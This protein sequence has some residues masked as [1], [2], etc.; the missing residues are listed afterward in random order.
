MRTLTKVK[1]VFKQ[2]E[3]ELR[4]ITQYNVQHGKPQY[5]KD[6]RMELD[7]ETLASIIAKELVNQY[8]DRDK[9]YHCDEMEMMLTIEG[10]SAWLKF[11]YILEF[12]QAGKPVFFRWMPESP[13]RK[14][15][16]P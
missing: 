4:L 1:K 5:H 3:D 2:H 8:R 6:L 12:N 9:A 10:E 11:T 16:Q 15:G 7:P 14:N 13:F